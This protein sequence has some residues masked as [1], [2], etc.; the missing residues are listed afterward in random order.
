MFRMTG[1]LLA[2]SFV[3]ASCAS[4]DSFRINGVQMEFTAAKRK[5]VIDQLWPA[6]TLRTVATDSRAN[7]S[8]HEY[9]VAVI[10]ESERGAG[11]ARCNELKLLGIEHWSIAARRFITGELAVPATY[12]DH[13]IVDACGDLHF[14]LVYDDKRDGKLTM[15]HGEKPRRGQR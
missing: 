9:I 4:R 11:H 14:W 3:L 15:M 5:E 2:A 10:G 12:L 6:G 8:D 1:Y 13:W 7:P